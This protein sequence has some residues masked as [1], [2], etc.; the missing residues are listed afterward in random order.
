MEL[1]TT[2]SPSWDPAPDAALRLFSLI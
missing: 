1:K 2:G